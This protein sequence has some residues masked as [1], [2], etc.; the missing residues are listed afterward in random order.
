MKTHKL[1]ALCRA[2]AVLAA[3]TGMAS[4]SHAAPPTA[5]KLEAARNLISQKNISYMVKELSSPAYDGR[6]PG[7]AGD[8]ASRDYIIGLFKSLKLKPAGTA[9]YLLPFTTTITQPDG[10]DGPA[11]PQ[12][13]ITA[14]TSNIIGVLPGN[15]PL[16][17]K[18]VILISGHRDHLGHTPKGVP[19][20]GANDDASG[21]A[22]MVELARAF[23]KLNTNNKRTIM[24]VAF[25][26]EEQAY[27]GSMYQA[28]NPVPA[29]PNENIVLVISID[30]IG[31]GFDA[32]TSFSQAKKNRFAETWFQ[33]V[34][35]GSTTHKDAYSFEYPSNSDGSDPGD[36][37]DYDVGPFAALGVS[38]RM[39][40][41]A[42]VPH[43][44]TTK[45]TWKTVNFAATE[46]LTRTIFDFLWKVDQ[47]PVARVD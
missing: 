34:Y 3:A 31:L 10:E 38:N 6:L 14:Q 39:I 1:T 13:G 40:G 35:N 36:S 25:G 30:M 27:M 44:H 17:R 26:A 20:A 8:A 23:S 47:D 28:A 9:G 4:P 12:L 37:F 42:D 45:D 46:P 43:Y 29:V 7:T 16:L 2:I 5:A 22:A 11:N 33:E 15:D 21:V 32:W 24:F 19:Y 41:I 18:E